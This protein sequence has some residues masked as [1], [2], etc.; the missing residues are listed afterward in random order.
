MRPEDDAEASPLFASLR[1]VTKKRA[2][3]LAWSSDAP[4]LEG[5]LRAFEPLREDPKIAAPIDKL[6]DSARLP[7]FLV[8]PGSTC[9]WLPSDAREKLADELRAL[10]PLLTPELS[11]FAT[12]LADVDGD[13]V[14]H[15]AL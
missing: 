7:W 13:V 12:A 4:S 8:R 14:A 5:R 1:R 15:D 2:L 9:G 10:R 11:A 3:E 6:L